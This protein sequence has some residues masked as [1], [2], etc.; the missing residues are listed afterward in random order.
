MH[1]FQAQSYS[2]GTFGM[3]EAGRDGFHLC[4]SVR[5]LYDGR[6]FPA[7][8]KVQ[9]PLGTTLICIVHHPSLRGTFFSVLSKVEIVGS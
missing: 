1:R 4:F 3:R 8:V 7:V 6:E 9:T 5:I 2:S